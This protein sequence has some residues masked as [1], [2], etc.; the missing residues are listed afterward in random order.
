MHLVHEAKHRWQCSV[1]KRD[2]YAT[3]KTRHNHA[4]HRVVS[5]IQ[6]V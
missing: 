5:Y 3:L 2:G 6:Y 4:D 1:V